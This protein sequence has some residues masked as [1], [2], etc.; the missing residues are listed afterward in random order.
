MLKGIAKEIMDNLPGLRTIPILEEKGRMN[1]SDLQKVADLSWGYVQRKL[2]QLSDYGLLK[3]N[4][5]GREWIYELEEYGK[6]VHYLLTEVLPS[7]EKSLKAYR[8]MKGLPDS[9]LGSDMNELERDNVIQEVSG[10]DIGKTSEVVR[11]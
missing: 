11:Y 1:L 7:R 10:M 6:A 4:R 2:P 8:A 3:R 9:K 5:E